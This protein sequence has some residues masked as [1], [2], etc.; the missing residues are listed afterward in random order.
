MHLS[1]IAPPIGYPHGSFLF[2]SISLRVFRRSQRNRSRGRTILRAAAR[3]RTGF[4]QTHRND[5]GRTD[6]RRLRFRSNESSRGLRSDSLITFFIVRRRLKQRF[7]P[8]Q[9]IFLLP[10]HFVRLNVSTSQLFSFQWPCANILRSGRSAEETTATRPSTIFEIRE[11]NEKDGWESDGLERS[12]NSSKQRSAG[13]A[14]TTF[15]TV[16]NRFIPSRNY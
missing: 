8:E 15:R 12:S 16:I 4:A 14:R 13:F 7:G 11:C 1:A 6:R 2:R 9:T 10:R 3:P 5:A